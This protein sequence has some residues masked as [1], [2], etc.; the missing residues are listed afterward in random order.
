MRNVAR[1]PAPDKNVVDPFEEMLK[2]TGCIELH[3]EL[4]DCMVEHQDWRK[5]QE[6]V[7]KFKDCMEV[8]QKKREESYS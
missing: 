8:Y 3:Y 1:S 7:K 4:Q 5:C 6:Q 2:K